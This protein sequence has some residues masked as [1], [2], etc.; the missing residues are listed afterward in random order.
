MPDTSSPFTVDPKVL[1]L[2]EYPIP[3]PS[4]SRTSNPHYANW[5]EDIAI[6]NGQVDFEAEDGSDGKGI[7]HMQDGAIDDLEL[8][9]GFG[10]KH[11][12][13]L[14]APTRVWADASM[15]AN[16]TVDWQA[17]SHFPRDDEPWNSMK[18]QFAFCLSGPDG[19]SSQAHQNEAIP[20]WPS[21][22]V[23]PDTH[24][25]TTYTSYHRRQTYADNRST[26]HGPSGVP[27]PTMQTLPPYPQGTQLY[28]R[29]SL[30]YQQLRQRDSDWHP[31]S[32]AVSSASSTS[33]PVPFPD[34]DLDNGLS[35]YSHTTVTRYRDQPSEGTQRPGRCT[36]DV[37][38]EHM[39]E[40]S[41]ALVGESRPRSR[42]DDSDILGSSGHSRQQQHSLRSVGNQFLDPVQMSYNHSPYH[43]GH[44]H[45]IQP[46]NDQQGTTYDAAVAQYQ[47]ND[48]SRQ[49]DHPNAIMIPMSSQRYQ[50][51]R[52]SSFPITSGF[53]PTSIPP[54]QADR[55][56]QHAHKPRRRRDTVSTP[57]TSSTPM[58]R[59]G[60]NKSARVSRSGS[61][62]VIREDPRTSSSLSSRGLLK[63][64]RNGPL[65]ESTRS[66]AKQK[67]IEKTVCVRCHMM[68][69]KCEGEDPCEGCRRNLNVRPRG[70]RCMKSHFLD[71]IE[72][73]S[74]NAVFQRAISPLTL[75]G[76][77]RVTI[78]FS[79]TFNVKLMLSRLQASQS[80]YTF[81]VHPWIGPSYTLD[82][83]QCFA[84]LSKFDDVRR[85]DAYE[86]NDFMDSN[87]VA[88]S[89]W[90]EC[91]KDYDQSLNV[92]D[93]ST[94]W[95]TMPSRNGYDLVSFNVVESHRRLDV[96]NQMDLEDILFAVQ[97]CRII[98]RALEIEAFSALQ[99]S[100]NDLPKQKDQAAIKLLGDQLGQLLLSLRWRIAWWKLFDNWSRSPEAF[101]SN[102]SERNTRL[103]TVLYCYYFIARNKAPA[104]DS[105][106]S[107]QSHSP[108]LWGSLPHDESPSG[109]NAW[110]QQ[111]QNLIYQ[112]GIPLYQ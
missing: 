75:D 98:L 77:R 92:L 63:G 69:Q 81:L 37:M 73:E 47:D 5:D 56:T 14:S 90:L 76:G 104:D 60:S 68:K 54:S 89:E 61:L 105:L 52:P 16:S 80:S 72:S 67:R 42:S 8:T 10:F 91:I 74:C 39:D 85:L 19:K 33:S 102:L 93:L 28:T 97:L 51:D 24:R 64:R 78:N 3:R 84:V 96:G 53:F 1:S 46:T 108:P 86:L 95:N 57:N 34:L 6:A 44:M 26:R 27:N 36:P 30:S 25:P 87:V 41:Q 23:A 21:S 20:Q 2:K 4:A 70:H 111:G 71:L 101:S 15:Y 88:L 65:S 49:L 83:A 82:L 18:Q 50:S 13:A 29:P 40:M 38:K 59:K 94:R 103:T 112:A 48:D 66:D 99:R 55:A 7:T 107:G 100:I 22:L 110:M 43:D 31:Q 79:S 45:Q 106:R 109:Y 35:Q 17:S 58:R 11:A 9:G 12:Q 62:N 32:K